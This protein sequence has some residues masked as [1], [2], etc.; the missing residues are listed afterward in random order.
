M[1]IKKENGKFDVIF[2]IAGKERNVGEFATEDLALEAYRKAFLS[3]NG[4]EPAKDPDF[5]EWQ[6][7]T[8]YRLVKIK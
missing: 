4:F 7:V 5:F 8:I 3:V 1:I 6:P 2:T